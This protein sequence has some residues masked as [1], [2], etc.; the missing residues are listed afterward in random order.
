MIHALSQ[1]TWR[2]IALTPLLFILCAVVDVAFAAKPLPPP[3]PAAPTYHPASYFFTIDLDPRYQIVG[4]G[5][6]TEESAANSNCYRFLYNSSG[7]LQEIEYRRAG[8]QMPDPLLG[9]ARIDFEYQPGIERRL[10]RN[11]KGE[12]AQDVDGVEGEELTLNPAG[13]PTTLTNIDASGGHTRDSSGVISYIRTLDSHNRLIMG[14]RVG[15]LGTP[16]T[17]NN[18]YFESRTVYD[19]QGRTIERG[20][21]DSSGN[22]LDDNDGIALVRTTYTIYPDST[23][24]IQSSMPPAWLPR[25]KAPACISFNAPSIR[26]AFSSTNPILIRRGL[27]PRRTRSACMS[28]ATLTTTGEINFPRAISMWMESPSTRSFWDMRESSTNTTARIA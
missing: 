25:R 14:R 17:D 20:N 18:G 19:E 9:V 26:G 11:E 1:N 12:P 15:L 21:Y 16:I 28:A 24:S 2:K 27:P 10:Y 4:T 13:Y 7:K 23:Q 22:L 8:V 3:E 5:A 6:L